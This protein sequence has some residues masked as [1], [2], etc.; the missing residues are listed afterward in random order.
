MINAKLTLITSVA[1]DESAECFQHHPTNDLNADFVRVGRKQLV[2]S[3]A[4]TVARRYTAGFSGAGLGFPRRHRRPELA[5][6]GQ[7]VT[8]G[9]QLG[10][11]PSRGR[12]SATGSSG[13]HFRF[14]GLK[15]TQRQ[16]DA[17][18]R[19]HAYFPRTL[20]GAQTEVL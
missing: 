14:V 6:C 2:Q 17:L 11:G 20:D 9:R 3:S 18:A 19:R 1:D 8:V 10:F 4:L 5:N 16:R 7:F 15:V 13:V 12:R